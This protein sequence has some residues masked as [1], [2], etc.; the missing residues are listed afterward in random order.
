MIKTSDIAA[1]LLFF[2]ARLQFK[3]ILKPQIFPIEWRF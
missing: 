1:H 2:Y 3:D